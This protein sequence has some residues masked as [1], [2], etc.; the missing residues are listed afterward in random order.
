MLRHTLT[1]ATLFAI[2]TCLIIS[3][4]IVDGLLKGVLMGGA[5]LPHARAV[6]G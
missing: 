2:L 5:F 3:Y 6:V 1:A 4:I